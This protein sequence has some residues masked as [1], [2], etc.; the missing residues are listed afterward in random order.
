MDGNKIKRVIGV[1]AIRPVVQMA[2]FRDVARGAVW[3]EREIFD[4]ELIL[5]VAGRFAYERRGAA[6]VVLGAGDVLLIPPG[7]WHTLRR[8]DEPA[9]AAFSCIHGELIPGARWADGDYRLRPKPRRVTATGNDAAIHDLFMRCSEVFEGYDRFRAELL[10]AMARELWIRLAGYWVGGGG[11]PIP[12]RIRPMVSHMRKH[13]R[14][15]VGRRELARVFRITPEHVNALF[16]KELGVTPTQFLHR[17][18]MARAYRCLRDQGMSVKEAAAQVGFDDPFYFSR[19]FKRTFKRSPS[20]LRR[21][22]PA[23]RSW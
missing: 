23:V 2:N 18:R 7:E 22:P 1:E 14:E 15:R 9:H 10:E 11:G 12:E 21:A 20:S 4:L 17:E 19:V 3:G 13:L 8:L 5:V 16:R 6:P